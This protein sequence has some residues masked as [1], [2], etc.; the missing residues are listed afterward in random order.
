[1]PV[2][3][4][5]NEAYRSPYDKTQP[6]YH[7]HDSNSFTRSSSTQSLHNDYYPQTKGEF[8]TD[9]QIHG[10]LPNYTP[11]VKYP[12]LHPITDHHSSNTDDHHSQNENTDPHQGSGW[13]QPHEESYLTEN[14]SEEI[15]NQSDC[16]DLINKVL[17][18]KYCRRILKRLL[19]DNDTDEQTH[20][21]R[22]HTKSKENVSSFNKVIEGF[23]TSV[24]SF[25]SNTVKNIIIY[26]LMGLLI[27]CILDLV[28]KI[29]Q[30][31]KK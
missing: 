12:P 26:G 3:A 5:I 28:F 4:S 11:S 10:K 8:N 1:M 24:F 20:V 2:G 22:S 21:Q 30:L 14:K 18:N 16:D 6:S 13:I 31:V 27:L 7:F 19:L 23:N 17:A 25:D 9:Y 15:S 29:G